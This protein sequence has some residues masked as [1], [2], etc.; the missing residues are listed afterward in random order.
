MYLVE[1]RTTSLK[2]VIVRELSLRI[3]V[4]MR[5]LRSIFTAPR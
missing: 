5:F 4:Y 1:K 2:F 3:R